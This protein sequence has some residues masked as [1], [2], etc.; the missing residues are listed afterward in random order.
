M[1]AKRVFTIQ[2]LTYKKTMK[3]ITLLVTGILFFTICFS[4]NDSLKNKPKMLF[5]PYI[6]NGVFFFQNDILK[7]N[8]STKSLY[9]WGFGLQIGHTE[10]NKIVPFAQLSLSDFKT[11]K[12]TSENLI[13]D[14]TI[15]IKQFN[16]GVIIPIKRIDNYIFTTKLSYSH[17]LIKESFFKIDG[18]ANGFQIGL[19]IERVMY[20][21]TRIYF[22]L[23]YNFQKTKMAEF[24]DFDMTKLSIGFVI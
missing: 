16:F 23:S 21:H 20:K 15:S 13:A 17:A 1:A 4:Q 8:Y 2:K 14:S 18:K 24:N 3:K 12:M 6:E 5:R 11:S 10:S 9:Y 7:D 19:G 22:D